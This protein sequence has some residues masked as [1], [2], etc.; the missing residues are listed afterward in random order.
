MSP[1]PCATATTVASPLP[2]MATAA[3]WVVCA[4]FSPCWAACNRPRAGSHFEV[5]LRD[6]EDKPLMSAGKGD[7]GNEGIRAGA[8]ECR[9]TLAEVEQE[10][11]QGE[12]RYDLPRIRYEISGG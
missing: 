11:F 9:V 8:V 1:L 3:S 5:G 7:V 2:R 6:R 12:R 10:P 4:V